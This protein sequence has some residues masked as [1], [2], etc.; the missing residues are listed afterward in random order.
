MKAIKYLM[1][2]THTRFTLEKETI[3]QLLCRLENI[4]VVL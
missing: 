4:K 3:I 2:I 1:M